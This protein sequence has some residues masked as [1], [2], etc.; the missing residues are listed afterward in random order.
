MPR[1]V[2]KLNTTWRWR[3][4]LLDR[5]VYQMDRITG[6][7]RL[8]GTSGG[9]PVPSQRW[10][11]MGYSNEDGFQGWD[12][13]APSLFGWSSTG[14]EDQPGLTLGP[15][16]EWFPIHGSEHVSLTQL[17]FLPPQNWMISS[18]LLRKKDPCIAPAWTM[19][20]ERITQPGQTVPGSVKL[21][22]SESHRAGDCI[23]A[24]ALFR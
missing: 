7:F 8:D 6:Y 5:V 24:L 19:P 20:Q 17:K 12:C 4:K 15:E 1:V 23:H 14:D 9:G 21:L 10:H 13:K 22:S 11:K 3:E 2:I 18:V 16:C